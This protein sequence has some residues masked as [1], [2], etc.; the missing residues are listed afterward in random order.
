MKE[1]DMSQMMIWSINLLVLS[2]GVFVAGMIKPK[3]IFFWMDKPNRIHIQL[4]AVA[5]FMG[6]AV[7]FA[8]ANIAKKD[9]QTQ[10]KVEASKVI[11]ETP[12]I[13]EKAK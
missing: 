10:A 3:W 1:K 6:A 11:E 5:L 4:F 2:L 8:E 12:T 7:L 9:E 13:E